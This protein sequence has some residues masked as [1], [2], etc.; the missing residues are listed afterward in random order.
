MTLVELLSRH[1]YQKTPEGVTLASGQLTREYV[2]CRAAMGYAE[3]LR[4]AAHALLD[5]MQALWPNAVGGLAMG[6]VPL[7]AACSFASAYHPYRNLRSFY[8]RDSRKTHGTNRMIE[9]AVSPGDRI[10]LVEDV[11]TTGESVVTAVLACQD[12][13]L[14]VAQVIALVDREQRGLER[15]RNVVGAEVPVSALT[16]LSEIRACAEGMR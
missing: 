16:T 11:V 4:K 12:Y 9:G 13:G 10:C 1:A 7:A 6:A 15:I 3:V 14:H 5:R 8:I 2:D